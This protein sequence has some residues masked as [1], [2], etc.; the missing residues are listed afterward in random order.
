MNGELW[1]LGKPGFTKPYCGKWGSDAMDP[2]IPSYLRDSDE[3]TEQSTKPKKPKR[4]VAILE[5]QERKHPEYWTTVY[6]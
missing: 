5:D 2:I 4:T 1:A 3:E 6:S